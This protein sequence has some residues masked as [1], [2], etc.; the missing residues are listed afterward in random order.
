M[1]GHCVVDLRKIVNEGDCSSDTGRLWEAEGSNNM[2]STI[3][4]EWCV[5]QC[6]NL[7]CMAISA[8]SG[9]INNTADHTVLLS[10]RDNLTKY[11]IFH[12]LFVGKFPWKQS[13]TYYKHRHSDQLNQ[14]PEELRIKLFLKIRY[15]SSSSVFIH[16]ALNIIGGKRMSMNSKSQ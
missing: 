16:K 6:M 8:L 10:Q 15:I 11:I 9:L 7:I 14:W 1:P 12:F 4:D 3:S 2:K 13:N 5:L